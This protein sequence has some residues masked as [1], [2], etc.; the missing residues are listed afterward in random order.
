M[1]IAMK[2]K[3]AVLLAA[4]L[5]P[6]AAS[7]QMTCAALG[8]F[9]TGKPYIQPVNA[10][11]PLAALAP[12]ATPN[13]CEVNFI[14]SAKEGA[15]DGYAPDQPQRIVIRVGL[16]LNSLEGGTGGVEGAWN[17][18]VMNLGGGGLAGNVGAVTSATNLGY[19][20]SSTDSGHPAS[21][22]PNFAVVQEEHR[23]NYGRLKDFL[24]ESLRVQYQ[25]ALGLAALYYDRRAS[26][27]YWSGC[28][29]GG[30]QGLSLALKFGRHFDGFLVGAPANFNSRL[31]V[32]TLWP[33]WVNKDIAGNTLTAAQRSATNA[34]AVAACDAQDG[35]VDGLLSDPRACKYDA[36]ANVCGQ[37]GAPA[38]PACLTPEQATA[39]NMIWDGPR[40]DHGT[41]IWFPFGIGAN[42]SVSST[43]TCGNLGSQCW[44]HRDTTFDWHP[45]PLSEFDD[46]TQLAT[47]VVAPF[48]DIISTDLDDVKKSRGKILM[49]HGGA[50]PLI[51]WRQSVHYYREAAQ[52]YDGYS[53]LQSWFRFYLA[54]GVGHCG[55]GAGPQPQAL[56]DAMVNWAENGAAPDRILSTNT[57]GG[58][59]TRSR[60]MCPYPK[61]AVYKGGDPNLES[62]FRC[63]GSIE[64]K[65]NVCMDLVAKYQ[66][67][68]RAKLDTKGMDNPN[69]CKPRHGHGHDDDDD[70]DDHDHGHHHHDRHDRHHWLKH[71]F[72]WYR[73]D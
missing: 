9:L 39:M 48:S 69:L 28:S 35:V 40:N 45:L 67:E 43:A 33:W 2:T 58:V 3:L 65:E 64:T 32:T 36:K 46:E 66:H 8:T 59:V 47:R 38:A 1:E 11:T 60:P 5:L 12:A 7:A 24:V 52:R 23:L 19:V 25:S 72:D 62:S 14:Y 21:E 42:E 50:D 6:A 63:E 44:A 15:E 29:T 71:G 31:Q 16:P 54:P 26:H 56:F 68:T 70:G 18:K 61:T 37:P 30:R 41:R 55:G 4:A 27:N 13:R 17:G 10:A 51:P 49:W 73:A 34:S 22:N 20:G 53:K 57:T